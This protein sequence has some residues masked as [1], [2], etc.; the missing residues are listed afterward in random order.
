MVNK[1]SLKGAE[2]TDIY[3]KGLLTKAR[4]LMIQVKEYCLGGK[5]NVS[6]NHKHLSCI[7]SALTILEDLFIGY[8]ASN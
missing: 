2:N 5:F 4:S 7:N 6:E 1:S 3:R 8:K